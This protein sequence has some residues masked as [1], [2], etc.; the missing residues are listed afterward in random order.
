[1]QFPSVKKAV[2][3]VVDR[4]ITPLTAESKKCPCCGFNTNLLPEG[5]K[6]TDENGSC[7]C[8]LCVFGREKRKVT[9]RDYYTLFFD[10]YNHPDIVKQDAITPKKSLPSV[11]IAHLC[12][13]RYSEYV[14]L[15][16]YYD[17]ED[18]RAF[19]RLSCS[20]DDENSSGYYNTESYQYI[21]LEEAIGLL[22]KNDIHFFDGL[23]DETFFDFL[24]RNYL[25]IE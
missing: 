7:Y 14:Y 3:P 8:R 6:K 4:K 12:G 2:A 13:E 21:S 22:N 11:E 18:K 23:T 20:D 19:F 5:E 16:M 24:S 9:Q 17:T 15:D 25:N 1:M 10:R